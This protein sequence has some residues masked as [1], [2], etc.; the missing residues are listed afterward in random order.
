MHF[1]PE[2][3]RYRVI[4]QMKSAKTYIDGEEKMNIDVSRVLKNDDYS[5]ENDFCTKVLDYYLSHKN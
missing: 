3:R 1:I 2:G 5:D 4:W